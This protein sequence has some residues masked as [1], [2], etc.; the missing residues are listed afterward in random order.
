MIRGDPCDVHRV[1]A[2]GDDQLRRRLACLSLSLEHR[3]I[4]PSPPLVE[5]VRHRRGVEEGVVAG[6][7]AARDAVHRPGVDVVG[8]VWRHGEV[9]AVVAL[10]IV[11]VARCDDQPVVG[12]A[13]REIA[14]E[15][16]GDRVSAVDSECTALG[17]IVLNVD[18]EQRA[19]HAISIFEGPPPAR[20][21]CGRR[22]L[23]RSAWGPAAPRRSRSTRR[24]LCAHAVNREGNAS[25]RCPA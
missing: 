8:F 6:A 2:L 23:R 4:G 1:D 24:I 20:R 13:A 9:T 18:D 16:R 14:G 11:P 3:V 25:Q 15:G 19:C 5:V 22:H 12:G 10:R 17:E 7:L 21:R